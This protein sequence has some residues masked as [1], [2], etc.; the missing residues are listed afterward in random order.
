VAADGL[1]VPLLLG[2]LVAEHHLE[3]LLVDVGHIVEVKGLLAFG[4]ID[5]LHLPADGLVTA[6]VDL[7]AAV[8][9]QH[10]LDDPLHVIGVGLGHLGGTVDPRVIDGHLPAGTLHGQ[11]QG[12]V[13]VLQKGLV[14]LAQGDKSLVQ[15]GDV[16]YRD[17]DA[18]MLHDKPS[19]SK[20]MTR[21]EADRPG[22][23][24]GTSQRK[25]FF[26]YRLSVF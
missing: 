13:R 18:K 7:E 24:V 5:L 14:E 22:L 3:R 17:F 1:G 15:L 19:Q 16:L 4:G 9:P 12:L 20:M 23:F 21:L 2:D 8:K 26:A 10:G 25:G 6:D 11:V